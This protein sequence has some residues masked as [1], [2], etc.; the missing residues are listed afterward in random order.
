MAQSVVTLLCSNSVAF[1]LERTSAGFMS[2]WHSVAQVNR[3]VDE[4]KF[5]RKFKLTSINAGKP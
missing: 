4:L 5:G 2:T 1:G 3:L